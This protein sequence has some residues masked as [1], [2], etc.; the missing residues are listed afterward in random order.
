MPYQPT[1]PHPYLESIDAKDVIGGNCFSVIINS[2]DII[3]KYDFAIF[4]QE[5]NSETKATEFKSI[6]SIESAT[7]EGGICYGAEDGTPLRIDVPNDKSNM[8][9]GN[10]YYWQITLY[11]SVDK[12]IKSP[13]YYFSAKA[14]PEITFDVP[15]K[16]NTCEYIFNATYKQEQNE[17]YMH[18]QYFLYRNNVL[19]DETP[20]MIDS[21]LS[22]K[23]SGFISGNEYKIELNITTLDRNVYK[24]LRRFKVEYDLQLSPIL[25]EV[26]QVS[27]KNCINVDFS[28][29]I[30]IK[31]NADT[32]VTYSSYDGSSVATLPE[33]SSIYYNKITEKD[34]LAIGDDFTVYYNVHFSNL[35]VGDIISLIDEES[36]RKY[37]VKYDGRKFL[38]KIGY[39]PW[40]E[41]DPYID[42]NGIH[43]ETSVVA[44]SETT[45]KDIDTNTL[46]IL[47]PDDIIEADSKIIYNDIT[48]NFWWTFVLLPEKVLVFKGQRYE[49]SVVS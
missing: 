9:N 31:G 44:S 4:K 3:S 35:F 24:L 1:Q 36:G 16:I 29:N 41:I 13:L 30:F 39:N 26:S 34:P 12:F 49:E 18:Y 15:E 8:E 46:Y 2:R 6:Y 42:E 22:Y 10:D 45:L 20:K 33:E 32:E 19:I 21:L 7:P 48:A 23:Y 27:D 5:V 14:T 43:Q 40:V 17:K 47:Y 28:Q 38:Y 37:T 25:P 11:D